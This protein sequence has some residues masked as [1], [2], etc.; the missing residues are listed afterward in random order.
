MLYLLIVA[1]ISVV[2]R[3]SS[4][5]SAI[6]FGQTYD[7]LCND[8]TELSADK[9][10]DSQQFLQILASRSWV[11]SNHLNHLELFRRQSRD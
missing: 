2:P 9:Y 10:V 1:S 4:E 8:V 7:R 3:G 11:A 5:C 6:V